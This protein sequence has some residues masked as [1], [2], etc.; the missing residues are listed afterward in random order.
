VTAKVQEE[1]GGGQFRGVKQ[2]LYSFLDL[3]RLQYNIL[4]LAAGF[5]LGGGGETLR[6]TFGGRRFSRV[7]KLEL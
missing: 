3:L 2:C 6:N 1:G 4:K 5:T 7:L